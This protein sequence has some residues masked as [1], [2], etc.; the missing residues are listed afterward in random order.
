MS[1]SDNND[2]L[3]K[4]LIEQPDFQNQVRQAVSSDIQDQMKVDLLYLAFKEDRVSENEFVEILF[5]QIIRL[6]FLV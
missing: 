5:H 1:G 4:L 6:L 3:S 2:S